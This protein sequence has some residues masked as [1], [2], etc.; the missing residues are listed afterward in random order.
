MN[1][2]AARSIKAWHAFTLIE[3]LVVIAI[4][5]ILAGMLL[6][7]LS[8]AKAKSVQTKCISNQKQIGLAFQLYA[9]DNNDLF[10]AQGGW[11]AAGGKKGN[12]TLDASVATS[13]GVAIPFQNRPLN[14][15]AAAENVWHCPSD[16]GDSLY[17]AKSC[18]EGYGN[19]YLP[20]FQHDSFR[21]KHVVGDNRLPKNDYGAMPIKS[22]EI[23]KS[24]SNKIIQGDWP[25]HANRGNTDSRS[26]WHNY[27]GKQRF[28][29]LFGDLHVEFFQFPPENQMNA[30]IWTAPDPAWKWW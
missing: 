22:S 1:L 11:G 6:P 14:K 30:W 4:I 20:Q 8:K 19:S 7:A 15:Y 16:K 26:A 24:P 3:L 5:A 25:W 29:M 2:I 21:V 23:A 10:P 13:F 12:Y 9:D 17:N 28:N 27:K 18:F